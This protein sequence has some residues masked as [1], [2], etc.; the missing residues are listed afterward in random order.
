MGIP[1]EWVYL[2]QG[3]GVPGGR[4]TREGGRYTRNG[5]QMYGGLGIS[6]GLM[7]QEWGSGGI[8]GGWFKGSFILQRKRK[9]SLILLSQQ[10]KHTDWKQCNRSEATSLSRSL[11][12][13]YK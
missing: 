4:Y 11:S 2:E 13:Q 10:Y 9:F 1:G 12:L 3:G 5:D 6:G 8:L 7:Y